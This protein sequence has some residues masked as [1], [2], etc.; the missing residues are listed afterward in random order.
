MHFLI[1]S[2]QASI[3]YLLFLSHPTKCYIFISLLQTVLHQAYLEQPFAATNSTIFLIQM[4]LI[5]VQIWPGYCLGKKKKK[6]SLKSIATFFAKMKSLNSPSKICSNTKDNVIKACKWW[7]HTGSIFKAEVTPMA[8]AFFGCLS[9][10][11]SP[12]LRSSWRWNCSNTLLMTDFTAG[13]LLQ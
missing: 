7:M 1:I 13:Q 4:W 2:R 3:L 6:R 10:V 8:N 12:S 11:N 5:L 9:H